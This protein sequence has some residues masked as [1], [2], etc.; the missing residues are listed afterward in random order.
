[1]TE[2]AI[3]NEWEYKAAVQALSKRARPPWVLRLLMGGLESYRQSKKMGWSRP[4]NKHGV[5]TFHSFELDREMDAEL[6]AAG[7]FAFSN[8]FAQLPSEKLKF[9]EQLAQ[10]PSLRC[11]LFIAEVQD[12]GQ[13]YESVTLSLGRVSA[14]SPRYRDRF[15]LI[16]DRSIEQGV[17]KDLARV[18]AYVDPFLTPIRRN[19]AAEYVQTEVGNYARDYFSACARFYL[20][21]WR[22]PNKAWDH[23]TQ[24]YIDYFGPRQHAVI[25]TAFPTELD[26]LA[27]QWLLQNARG[28]NETVPAIAPGG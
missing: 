18:R 9:V 7:V 1:M 12:E 28:A 24:E 25:G 13:T 6:V 2:S 27:Q 23:W 10:D 5:R 19:P 14:T 15:D 4:Q 20:D 16:I 11:F 22:D 8:E 26:K 21:N 17:A 3:T